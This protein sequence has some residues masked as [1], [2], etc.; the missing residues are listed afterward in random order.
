MTSWF[1][2]VI[3]A[4]LLTLLELLV[5]TGFVLLCFAVA[6]LATAAVS[7][8]SER[9]QVQLAAF[10]VATTVCF[11]ALRPFFQ[12]RSHPP[13]GPVR[14][15][16]HALLDRE[17]R[18]T[19][20]VTALGGQVKVGGEEWAAFSEGPAAIPV[21]TMVRVVAITGN[22]LRVALGNQG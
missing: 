13:G 4:G 2:W 18:V 20:E 17:A 6:C 7:L 8:V 15:N 22:R 10:S 21:G 12:R 14:T 9:L 11:V 5:P 3:V 1:V 16:V 19:A